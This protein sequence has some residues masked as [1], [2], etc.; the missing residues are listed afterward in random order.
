MKYSQDLCIF[1]L[2]KRHVSGSNISENLYALLRASRTL[3]LFFYGL[4]CLDGTIG[5]FTLAKANSRILSIF[6]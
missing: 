3:I 5:T 6:F 2:R 4:Q 1:G